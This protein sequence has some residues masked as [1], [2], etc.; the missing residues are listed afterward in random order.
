MATVGN[1]QIGLSLLTAPAL[2]AL[3]SFEKS[4]AAAGVRTAAIGAGGL[5][6][7]AAIAGAVVAAAQ[8][9]KQMKGVVR[10]FEDPTTGDALTLYS[11]KG[12]ELSEQLRAIA[13]EAPITHGEIAQIAETA[14]ALGIALPDLEEF[15]TN[16]VQLSA[17]SEDLTPDAVA[18]AFGKIRTVT[19]LAAEDFDSFTSTVVALGQAGASTEGEILSMAQRA[20]GVA[21]LMGLSTQELL[22]M[23]AAM[24]NI[25]ERSEA[26]GTSIQRMFLITQANVTAMNDKLQ[27]QADVLGLTK[28]QFAEAFEADSMATVLSYLSKLSSMETPDI[29]KSLAEAG[30]KDVRITRGFAN[31]ISAMQNAN[32]VAGDLVESQQIADKAWADGTVGATQYAERTN[33]LFDNLQ[34][35]QNKIYDLGISVGDFLVPHLTN[36][37]NIF[38]SIVDGIRAFADSS[39]QAKLVVDGIT[40]AILGLMGL[41]FGAKLLRLFLPIPGAGRIIGA[42]W[43]SVIGPAISGIGGLISGAAT[44][45][46]ALIGRFLATGIGSALMAAVPVAALAAIAVA[47]KMAGDAI[48]TWQGTIKQLDQTRSVVQAAEAGEEFDFATKSA[49]ELRAEAARL[50][51]ESDKMWA[52]QIHGVKL[53]TDLWS[54]VDHTFTAL[55]DRAARYEAAADRVEGTMRDNAK[56]AAAYA[57]SVKGVADQMKALGMDSVKFAAPTME[58]P[59]VPDISGAYAEE[60]RETRNAVAKGFGS[61]KAALQNAPQMID[62]DTRIKNAEGRLR[63]TIRNVK[64]AVDADDPVNV[65]YWTKASAKAAKR[66][67]TLKGTTHTTATAVAENFRQMGIDVKP[68]WTQM[69]NHAKSRGQAARNSL[70]MSAS[71][72]AAGIKGALSGSLYSEGANLMSTLADGIRSQIDTVRAAAEAVAA[73]AG[74]STKHG[75]P[76]KVGPLKNIDKDGANLVYQ[77]S[78]GMLSQKGLA[79]RTGAEVARAFR[80]RLGADLTAAGGSVLGRRKE[81]HYHVGTLI[82]DERGIDKLEQRMSRRRQRRARARRLYNETS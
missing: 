45:A 62:I 68:V 79:S 52:G 57:G 17:L 72:A 55:T 74:E 47:V 46:G 3:K 82:A 49:A 22:A 64:R 25:A 33:N 61:V 35:L 65:Q 10:T 81:N 80:P 77:L 23:S 76:P 4:V 20:S 58:K 70:I 60:M 15:V 19:G 53:V 7:T 69:A 24:A 44:G 27:A 36:L 6:A 29:F 59:K 16:V 39:D 21:S 43:A 32:D 28:E 18:R 9:E 12:Q 56:T 31:I 30:I 42:A 71:Q 11:E 40:T 34:R 41:K 38:S 75:S 13:R 48:T 54:N 26:G 50:R 66:V 51:A 73:A 63:K 37:V 2:A 8:W 67:D 14:G 78:K 5:V 1:L